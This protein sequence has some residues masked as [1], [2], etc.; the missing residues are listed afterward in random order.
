[1][2]GLKLTCTHTARSALAI[3]GLILASLACTFG[4]DSTPSDGIIKDVAT[5]T[6]LP[7][8]TPGPTDTPRAEA[9][10]NYQPIFRCAT[11]SPV[12]TT[13]TTDKNN[14]TTCTQPQATATAYILLN[15]FPLGHKVQVGPIG[16]DDLGIFIWI[17]N[18]DVYETDTPHPDDG[19]D[20]WIAV[21]EVYVE[22][23]SEEESFEFVPVFLTYILEVKL[24]DGSTERGQWHVDTDL[25]A[26][27][28]LSDREG[29]AFDHLEEFM[30]L[31]E[32]A[33]FT[34][35]D[36]EDKY[37]LQPGE[38]A[39]ARMATYIPGPE[40]SRIAFV[41]RPGDTSVGFPGGN[42]GIWRTE[43][44]AD[45]QQCPGDADVPPEGL[46]GIPLQGGDPAD[47]ELARWPVDGGT[48][49]RGFGCTAEFTG[50]LGSD[51]P[52]STPWFHNGTDISVPT[53]S[54]YYDTLPGS[55][56]VSYAGDDTQGT[57]C[58]DL[59]GSEEPHKGL[60]RYITHTGL[61][62]NHIITITAGH[63][64]AVDVLSFDST[65]AGMIMG[66]TGSTGCSTGPHLHFSVW[67]DGTLVDPTT[68][69]P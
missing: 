39:W 28:E 68:V 14:K 54:N 38:D 53:G 29:I 64:S 65:L 55:G 57:D 25:N 21:W 59:T 52:D 19:R 49:V 31:A 34:E 41:L 22:N 8:N 23:K 63:L 62:D 45:D 17:D 51:C 15:D 46:D 16:R 35:E 36:F 67:V 6:N 27:E 60:G 40:V 26:A 42:I 24:S 4:G 2:R 44:N 32:D 56:N 7:T 47:V 61:I 30:D 50:E 13:C 10:I 58:S 66:R 1:M 43:E 12:P 5:A 18:V 20:A 11:P 33:D 37:V 9:D 69:L 48:I 3:G